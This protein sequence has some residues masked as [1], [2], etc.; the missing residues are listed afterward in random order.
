MLIRILSASLHGIEAYQVEVEVDISPG[1]PAFIIVGLPDA[2]VRESKERV[3]AALR[4]C[5]FDFPAKKII[6]NLAPASRKKEGSAFDLPI[7]L[8]LLAY[9]GLVP[10]DRLSRFI[11]VGELT[12]EGSLK[13]IRGALP[14]SLLASRKKLSGLVLP[15]RNAR[16]ACLVRETAVYAVHH[17][18]EVIKLLRADQELRPCSYS[19]EELLDEA[20]TELDFS[21]VRGQQQAKRALEV[22]AAG[23]HNLLMIG[24]PGSGKTMLARRLPTILPEMTFAEIIEV[25]QVYSAAGLLG[26]RAAVSQRPFR[27]PHHTITDTGLI[28]G[29]NFPRPGEVS[30]AHRG[31]LFMDEFPEFSRQALESLR[32]PLEDGQVTISRVAGSLSYPCAFMLVAAMN[33]CADVFLGSGPEINCT[34]VERRKYYS[35]LSRPLLDRID[36]Q[37]EVPSVK[38]QDIVGKPAGEASADI[39]QRVSAARKRQ[40]ERF[41]GR[42][43]FA[44]ARMT[45]RDLR[46]YCS[47]D[48]EVSRL[49]ETAM[50]RFRFSARAYDRILKVARTIADLEQEEKISA[51]A[52]AEAIQY[53]ILDRF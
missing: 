28:G 45:S 3:R 18:L 36:I 2:A 9:L 50:K 51:A 40:L 30:L 35:R 10:A 19:L 25:T 32:Q 23:G 21:E 8:G 43:I 13:A 26:D 22:A 4:N 11:F 53:R 44:N 38:Y 7:A 34:E 31:V 27:A 52:V 20:P 12:L 15:G 24:P 49:M 47:L 39:R 42:K 48:L 41:Q 37:I 14:I 6:I 16:E 46:Q 17:L 29:G 5:G 33:P 1:L